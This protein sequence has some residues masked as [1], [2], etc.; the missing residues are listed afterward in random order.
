[1]SPHHCEMCTHASVRPTPELPADG[2]RLA[3]GLTR[4]LHLGEEL[5]NREQLLAAEGRSFSFEPFFHQW[6]DHYSYPDDGVWEAC[7]VA[8][9]DGACPAYEAKDVR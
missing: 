7:A 9:P 2:Q 4:L 8:N 5:M 1:M 6:C 3:K